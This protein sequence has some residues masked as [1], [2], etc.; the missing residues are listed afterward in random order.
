M[1]SVLGSAAPGSAQTAPPPS[2]FGSP[3]SGEIPILFNDAHVYAK[4]DTLRTGRVLA[5]LVRNGVILV[6]LRSMFEQLG[7]TVSWDAATRT[8][9]VSKPGSDVKVTLGRSIVVV[10]GGERPPPP[11]PPPAPPARAPPRGVV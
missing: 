7:A 1:T 6:P 2:A 3:P 8:A 9:D 5:A 4:P 11:P 10:N